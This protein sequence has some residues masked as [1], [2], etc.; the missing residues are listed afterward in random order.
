MPFLRVINAGLMPSVT[1]GPDHMVN[2]IAL[3]D[4]WACILDNNY[5]GAN[6]LRWMPPA[7]FYRKWKAGGQGWAVILLSPPPP[8]SYLYRLTLN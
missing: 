8:P 7:D 6:E 2:L 5:V 4:Q 3:T 1:W